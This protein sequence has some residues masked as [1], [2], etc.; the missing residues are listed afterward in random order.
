MTG[1]SAGEVGVISNHVAAG[2]ENLREVLV[3]TVRTA[4][5]DVNRRTLARYRFGKG[6]RLQLGSG[7]VDVMVENISEGGLLITGAPANLQDGSKVRIELPGL[8]APLDMIVLAR[9]AGQLRGRFDLMPG[10]AHRWSDQCQR[11]TRGLEP[12][13]GS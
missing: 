9:G 10:D 11:L 13:A 12:V 3:R 4:S 6:S 1:A 7:M 8:D 2:I 5:K